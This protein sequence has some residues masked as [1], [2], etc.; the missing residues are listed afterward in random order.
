CTP[1]GVMAMLEHYGISVAG[2][3]AVVIGRS[4]IVGKPMAQLLMD[5]QAT[6][7]ICHSKTRD[8]KEY[9]SRADIVVVAAGQPRFMGREHF[10]KNSVI[11]DVGMHRKPDG[12]LCGDVR[13]EEMEGWVRAATP[14]P[15]GV[16]LMTVTMLLENTLTLA[17]L[18]EGLT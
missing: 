2:A 11:M 1:F 6:V 3:Q 5:A 18:R 8:L 13:Y 4:N 7:T 14:V 9:T 17:E 16:G 10:K 12:K 15:G